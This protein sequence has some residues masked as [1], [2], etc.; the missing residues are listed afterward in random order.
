MKISVQVNTKLTQKRV[1]KKPSQTKTRR[2]PGNLMK[3][4][5]ILTKNP[6]TRKKRIEVL[7]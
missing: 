5:K 1:N 2:A 3:T 4:P 7:R 6:P